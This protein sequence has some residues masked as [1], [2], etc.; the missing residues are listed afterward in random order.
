MT[1]SKSAPSGLAP[2]SVN[3]ERSASPVLVR[4][5]VWSAEVP[6]VTVP[7]AKLVDETER[8]GMGTGSPVPLT[9]MVTEA[10]SGSSE[11]MSKL[12]L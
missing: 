11:G 8:F 3:T 6:T 10:V 4:V 2:P 5:R 7:K 9:L 12:S 1:S